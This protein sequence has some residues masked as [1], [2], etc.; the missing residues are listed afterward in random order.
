MFAKRAG[1]RALVCVF[2]LQAELAQAGAAARSVCILP[3]RT[4]HRRRGDCGWRG[5]G[6]RF[7]S[8]ICD[9]AP[10]RDARTC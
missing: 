7:V 1:A 4:G 9:R 3:A 6:F 10:M 2:G 8:G 5:P